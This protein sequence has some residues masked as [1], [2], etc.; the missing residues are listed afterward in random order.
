MTIGGWIACGLIALCI[1]SC[2]AFLSMWL[3]DDYK[4][5]SIV[6]LIFTVLVTI[7]PFIVGFWYYNNTESGMR[8]MKDQES[9][10]GDGI[11]RVVTVYDVN[12]NVIATYEGRFDIETDK[13]SYIL[14]DDEDGFRHVIY[15]TTGTITIDEIPG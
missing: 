5:V 14:F 2:G 9:N 7:V 6:T 8:A 1:A 4:G 11:N 13:D 15:Y 3:W 12:G 10:F